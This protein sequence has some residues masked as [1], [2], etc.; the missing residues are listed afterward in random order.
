MVQI[1]VMGSVQPTGMYLR[2][3]A[4]YVRIH[5]LGVDAQRLVVA[6]DGLRVLAFL[7]VRHPTLDPAPT[8]VIGR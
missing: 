3:S 2:R 6:L 1:Q 5:M 4:R 8:R 7:G